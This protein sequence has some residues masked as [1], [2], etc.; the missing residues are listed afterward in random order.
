MANILD[1]I[2]VRYSVRTYEPRPI[3]PTLLDQL[4]SCIQ[5]V[6]SGPFGHKVRFEL[7]DAGEQFEQELKSLI[8]YG[9]VKGARYFVA[10]AV[11]KGDRAMEDFGYC[12]ER[13]ILTATELGLGTVWL[14]GSL[15]RSAF[16]Q[17]LHLADNEV[18]PAISPLGYGAT[19]RSLM[20]RTIRTVSGGDRRKP[21]TELFFVGNFTTALDPGAAGQYYAVLDAVR[22]APSASN[23]QPWRIVK[24]RG[25][26]TFHLFIKE[27][28][29]YNSAIKDIK[30]QY[31]DMGI[32]LCH[33]ELAARE[34]GLPGSWGIAAPHIDS[35][36]LKY[37]ATWR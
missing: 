10:G 16:A 33:F 3:E 2:K 28:P 9:N 7:I 26:D 25:S 4:T 36:S 31:I 32:A 6:E 34:L 24:E 20:D 29:G 22:R 23:K 13:I 35:G 14:G 1:T 18:I 30:M 19:K 12:M 37:I 27:T 15:N 5:A 8:S 17:K 21:F 11:Q